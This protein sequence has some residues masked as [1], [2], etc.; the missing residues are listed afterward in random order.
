MSLQELLLIFIVAILI[1]KPDQFQ[2]IFKQLKKLYY[3]INNYKQSFQQKFNK[4]IFKNID[5]VENS[6]ITNFFVEKDMTKDDFIIPINNSNKLNKIKHKTIK[7][8]KKNKKFSTKL[9]QSTK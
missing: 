9:T 6:K 3:C 5:Y 7:T 4:T 2:S 8:R 1:L